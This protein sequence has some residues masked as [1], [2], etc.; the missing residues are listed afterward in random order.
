MKKATRLSYLLLSGLM[1]S[2]A[3]VHGGCEQPGE[4]L[5]TSQKNAAKPVRVVTVGRAD[6]ADVLTYV[7]DLKPYME[8]QVFST[9]PDRIVSFPWE[10]GDEVKR[11]Q[12]IALIRSS[13]LSKGLE[14]LAA[15]MDGLDVQIKNMK[16]EVA[17]SKG[18]LQKG[19]LTQ[20]QF[21]QIETG[22][23]SSQAQRRAL[24]ANR[25]QLSIT[26]SNAYITAPITGVIA[27][28][29]L[30]KGD[31][32]V[33][34]IPLCRVLAVDKLKADLR[35]VEA[36]VPK[37]KVGQKV[38]IYVDAYPEREFEGAVTGILPF[39][40]AA[41]RTNTVEVTI[42]NPVEEETGVRALKP[43]MYGRAVLVVA[44]RANTLVAPEP[45][46][47]LDNQLLEQQKPGEKLR[48]AYVAKNGK[49]EKRLVRLGARKGSLYQIL[50]GLNEG[51]QL[52]IRGQHGL[53][54]NQA[55][56]I[57]SSQTAKPQPQE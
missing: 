9:I 24:N 47:L 19:I 8:V 56:E 28:K 42:D 16:A 51:E 30:E 13:G 20:A 45:A 53:L 12:R 6:I 15:Q 32:A 41:T 52:I 36:E 10:E 46:L 33:P 25:G 4:A 34:Q 38:S 57:V 1:L 35:M 11:G 48:K 40:D 39:L 14:G 3:V 50:D 54:D 23:K 43:G 55:V 27:N 7:A 21:D 37:V 26:A 5:A 17:R 2:T 44:K 49:A 22:L 18:L 31:L 29:G